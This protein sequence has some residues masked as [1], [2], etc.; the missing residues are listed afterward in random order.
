[1]RIIYNISGAERKKLCKALGSFLGETPVYQG[2]PSYAFKVGE[3]IVDKNGNINCP[4]TETKVHMNEVI[5]FLKTDGFTP[6]DIEYGS[7]IISLPKSSFTDDALERLQILV[8]NKAPLFKKAFRTA[9]VEIDTESEPDK[10]QFP[11]FTLHGAD[12]ESLAYSQFITALS[13]MAQ[14]QKRIQRKDYEDGNDKFNMRLFLVRL[15]MIGA[16]YKQTRKILMQYLT[17]NSAW[18]N[19]H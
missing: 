18:K 4:D 15:G 7:L 12:G 11:W 3:Y 6:E 9:T 1:M 10:V 17:G 14:N 5:E 8:G 13:K 2:T 16:K 19:G